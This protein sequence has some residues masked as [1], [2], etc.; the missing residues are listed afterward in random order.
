MAGKNK[1]ALK[2]ARTLPGLNC[3]QFVTGGLNQS[4]QYL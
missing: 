3:R 4:L 1:Q 2:K